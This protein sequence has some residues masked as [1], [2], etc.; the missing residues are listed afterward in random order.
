MWRYG[1]SV[2]AEV[3]RYVLERHA[4]Y[5]SA[6]DVGCNVGFMLARL[7]VKPY[8]TTNPNPDPNPDLNPNLDS[9]RNPSPSPNPS[10]VML[11]RL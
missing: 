6:L 11:A 2:Q 9:N 1:P 8:C 7:Q 5:A 3:T 10:G 4:D